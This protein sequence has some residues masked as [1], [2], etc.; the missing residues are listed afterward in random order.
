MRLLT[1][2]LLTLLAIDVAAESLKVTDGQTVAVQAS[3]RELNRIRIDGGKVTHLRGPD[4][5][6]QAEA[7]TA[8]GEVYFRM[9]DPAS[10]PFSLF[11][12]A[13]NGETYTLLVTPRQIPAVTLVLAPTSG[14]SAL[15]AAAGAS[16]D[17]YTTRIKRLIRSMAMD[18]KRYHQIPVSQPVA[19]NKQWQ[20]IL[21]KR[22]P[23]ELEGERYTIRNVSDQSRKLDE[24]EFQ[25]INQQ[26]ALAV[27]LEKH[28]LEPGETTR[29]LLIRKSAVSGG[30]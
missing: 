21:E 5:R 27:A 6:I 15:P 9:A 22:W 4:D 19:L 16:T 7:D 25:W 18:D 20:L 28:W 23:G 13:D 2:L 14:A 11:V 12:S 1:L 26:Q 24:R 29:L 8:T 10:T 30:R 17:P 3:L